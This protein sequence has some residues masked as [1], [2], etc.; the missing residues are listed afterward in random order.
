MCEADPEYGA[1]VLAEE[2]RNNDPVVDPLVELA[3]VLA[4]GRFP[5]DGQSVKAHTDARAVETN[6]CPQQARPAHAHK[7]SR[8]SLENPSSLNARVVEDVCRGVVLTIDDALFDMQYTELQV[9]AHT[10]ALTVREQGNCAH[11][12]QLCV[13]TS[14]SVC[15]SQREAKAALSKKR[16]QLTVTVPV[17]HIYSV[18]D[19]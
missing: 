13:H 1:A 16:N 11:R 14:Q 9:S 6:T 12:R 4:L 3:S 17:L 15:L 7:D 19:A 10:I 18:A 8:V 2:R 5:G